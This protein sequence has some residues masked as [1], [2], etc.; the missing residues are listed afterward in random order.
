MTKTTLFVGDT[1][2][3]F[4]LIESFIK[5]TVKSE[6]VEQI[7]FVGDYLDQWNCD[8]NGQLYINELK[9]LLNFKREMTKQNIDVIFLVG[10]HDVPYLTQQYEYYSCKQ[11]NYLNKIRL[12]LEQLQPQIAF[13]VTD[14]VIVS[15]AGYI[16]EHDM[17]ESHFKPWFFDLIEEYT[18]L[19]N[20]VG[21]SRGGV[22][23]YGGVLWMDLQDLLTIDTNFKQIVGHTPVQTIDTT[24]NVIGIDTFSL[25]SSYNEIGDGSVLVYKDNEFKVIKNET[26]QAP[27]IRLERLVYF[28]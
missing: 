21:Q 27:E 10:N 11:T 4:G 5:E 20:K 22:Y 24:K 25:T 18:Y 6:N 3:Q 12:L 14:N 19:Q 28:S 1:H 26:W 23:F 2:L 9:L 16:N 7:V 8:T 15:H 13:K 17:K